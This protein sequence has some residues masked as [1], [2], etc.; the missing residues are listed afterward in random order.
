[1]VFPAEAVVVVVLVA[2]VVVVVVVAVVIVVVVVVET[3]VSVVVVTLIWAGSAVA[4]VS[5]VADEAAFLE[6]YAGS[7]CSVSAQPVASNAAAMTNPAAG[8]RMIFLFISFYDPSVGR[9]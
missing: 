3:V 2:V 8:R 9:N 4:S 6:R 5:V 7:V 1:M